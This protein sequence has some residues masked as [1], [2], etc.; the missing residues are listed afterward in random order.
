EDVETAEGSKQSRKPDR[1]YLHLRA[2]AESG[3]DFSSRW[4]HD[5]HDIRTIHT[6]DIIPVDLNCLLYEL[7]SGIAQAYRLMKN[8]LLAK[9]F[10]NLARRRASA[11]NLYCWSDNEKCYGDYNFHKNTMTNS[12]TLAMV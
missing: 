12:V 9:R 4:F 3:W 7:E 1:L 2:A 5:P 6:A 8:N 10:E 11:I